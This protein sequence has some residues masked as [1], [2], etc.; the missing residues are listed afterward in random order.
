MKQ[1]GGAI[2]NEEEADVVMR[3]A[4]YLLRRGVR[5]EQIGIITFYAAQVACLQRLQMNAA[6]EEPLMREL[7]ISTVDGF[8]G[9]ERDFTLISCVRT[10]HS[11]GFLEEYRRIN[12][13]LSRGKHARWVFGCQRAFREKLERQGERNCVLRNFFAWLDDAQ[14]NNTDLPTVIVDGDAI[15][16]ALGMQPTPALPT[17]VV[18]TSRQGARGGARPSAARGPPQHAR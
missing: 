3:T 2:S 5:P 16:G 8:Q 18:A 12:V 14:K 15:C 7:T 13:A 10:G 1:E 9:D 6:R 17:T 4:L 11:V